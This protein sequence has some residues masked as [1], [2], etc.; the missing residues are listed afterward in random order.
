[1][2]N[3]QHIFQLQWQ[4]AKIQ[5][6][7][8]L[9]MSCA[10]IKMLSLFVNCK[11]SILFYIL[12]KLFYK[13]SLREWQSLVRHCH[14]QHL[15]HKTA[16]PEPDYLDLFHY[17]SISNRKQVVPWNLHWF[18]ASLGGSWHDKCG[19]KKNK[20]CKIMIIKIIKTKSNTVLWEICTVCIP[21]LKEY[22]VRN[23]HCLGLWFPL[24]AICTEGKQSQFSDTCQSN[25]HDP[26]HFYF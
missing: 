3:W 19:K 26:K 7:L 24:A 13:L 5:K 16:T 8:C 22:W 23:L 6:L 18:E 1:M 12:L 20:T 4:F 14:T 10:P 11:N 25:K 21:K 2:A 9:V 17:S 15:T